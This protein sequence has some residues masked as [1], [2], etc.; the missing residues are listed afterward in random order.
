[1]TG[2]KHVLFRILK[3]EI[4]LISIERTV[5]VLNIRTW[6]YVS[7]VI[8][9]WSLSAAVEAVT[10][11][12]LTPME[13][14]AWGTTFGSLSLFIIIISTG[15]M[16]TIH[17]YSFR[18]HLRLLLFSMLGF[19]GYQ[20]LKYTAF[21]MVP[22]PQANILQYTYPIFIV[23]FALPVLNQKLTISKTVGIT[24][25]FIGAA[26]ILSGGS[27]VTLNRM[28]LNGYLIALGAG[29]SFGLFSVLASQAAFEPVSSMFFMQVYSALVMV[30]ILV[31]KGLLAFPSGINEIAG[32]FYAGVMGH[33]VGVM[34]LIAAQR[35]T[36]DVSYISGTLY[37]IPF[38]SLFA[39][40]LF[41][42]FPI[43]LYAFT[44]L[45]FIV[46]GMVIHT[47][48]SNRRQID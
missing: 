42:N 14:C 35:S 9:L 2:I 36:N 31:F 11:R 26:I 13:F 5:I 19:A 43:P 38:L 40:K 10:L 6:I 47:T 24:M 27:L 30:S 17:S 48:I 15:R 16:N 39:F 37:L 3:S 20:T 7:L 29:A 4:T 12:S 44:G 18:D 41:L 45:V 21:T 33:V 1:M 22:I 32:V 23:I 34:L 46:G 25:G 28:Y 8:I